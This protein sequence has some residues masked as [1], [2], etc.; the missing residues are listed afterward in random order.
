MIFLL[1][2]YSLSAWG[3]I[4]S[5][6]IKKL[7]DVTITSSVIKVMQ[8]KPGNVSIINTK[9]YYKT[10]QNIIDIFKR[11]SGVRIRVN[12][13]YGSRADFFLN[14]ITGKQVKFF[15]DGM[16]TDNLG[17]TQ[18][19][20]IIP[21]EQTE[22]VEVYKGVVPLELGSDALGGAINIV[23][24]KDAMDVL[25]V[26][27]AAGSFNTYKLNLYSKKYL[28][29]KFY[30]SALGSYNISDNN[31]PVDAEIPNQYGN[32]EIKKVKRF[33]NRFNFKNVKAIAGF[34]NTNWCDMFSIQLQAAATQDEIQHNFIMRQPYGKARFS[35]NINGI[36]IW[37]QKNKFVKNIDFNSIV[38]LDNSKSLFMDTALSVYNWE[39]K[40][41]DTRLIGGEI[42]SSGNL[43]S[44]HTKS[45]NSRQIIQ[46][47][48][49]PNIK[50][51][52]ANTLQYFN[53]TGKDPVATKFY[54]FDI[55]NNPQSAIKNIA[56]IS[57]ESKSL[58]DK[59]LHISTVKYHYGKIQ[60]NRLK[61]LSFEPINRTYNRI[62][63]NS[64]LTYFFSN[65]FFIK[66]SYEKTMRLPDETEVFGDLVLIKANPGLQP[67]LAE[68]INVSTVFNNGK[69][70]LEITGFYR[71]V[72][73]TIFLPPSILFSQYSNLL[74]MRVSGIEI[75]G[76]YDISNSLS[77]EGNITY[78]DLRN[79]SFINTSGI[80][81]DKYINARMPNIP[82]FFANAGFQYNHNSLLNKKIALQAYLYNSYVHNYY[83]YWSQDG[84]PELKNIIPK[85]FLQTLGFSLTHPANRISISC[86]VNNLLGSKMYDNYK[87]QLPG[88]NIN[89]KLR[90]HISH[91]IKK[92]NKK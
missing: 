87:V 90:Y 73:N 67:E 89:I 37:Y 47:H 29:P 80:N 79:R 58:K 23:T 19:I 91:T 45:L 65:K 50:I 12:G 31:Y 55:F 69:K 88:R 32:I 66:A 26:T 64:A 20:G 11:I 48:I 56:G 75:N 4:D 39:G 68:N 40:I 72:H 18:T 2:L 51:N 38:S 82:Y 3:Q 59:L 81:D 46:Y 49:S 28:S 30:I 21:V 84:D 53:R 5:A 35:S 77:I 15:I 25:D 60:G 43:L 86:E 54:G 10:N 7:E 16:P 76:K 27:A 17:E 57:I 63:Y 8:Q 14:G 34:T 13:G 44:T 42:S 52:I 24:R 36:Q 1:P 78:Q 61:D 83:L 70:A 6:A 9:P 74:K 33:H 85:Q 71:N 92:I 22:R 62:G 41:V